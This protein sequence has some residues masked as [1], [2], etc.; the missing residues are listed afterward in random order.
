LCWSIPKDERHITISTAEYIISNE[1]VAVALYD[2]N[3]KKT[4][5][6]LIDVASG[7]VNPKDEHVELP[8]KVLDICSLINAT[9]KEPSWTDQPRST[10]TTC[11]DLMFLMGCPWMKML[12][13]RVMMISNN[14]EAQ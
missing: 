13:K 3:L 6:I 2:Q 10:T 5:L 11:L 12:G 7:D 4:T 1:L 9:N 8:R 14:P